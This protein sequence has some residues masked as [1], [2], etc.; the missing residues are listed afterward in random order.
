MSD[1]RVYDA[2]IIGS[3]PNGLAAGIALSQQGYCVLILEAADTVGGGT[4]TEE[5]TLPGFL[6]DR[7]S[8]VHPMGVLSP[9]FQQLPLEE[10]G[11]EWIHPPFS[12]A[13]PMEQGPAVL[14]EESIEETALGLGGLGPDAEAYRKLVTPFVRHGDALMGDLLAPLRF[15]RFPLTMLRFGWLGIKSARSLAMGRFSG[16]AA[17]ALFAGCAAHSILPLERRLS[18]AV[19]LVFAVSGHLKSWPVAR[20][21]SQKIAE[22][23]ASYFTSLG[24]EI[25]TGWPVSSLEEVPETRAVIFDTSPAVMA[26]IA[27]EELPYGYQRRLK[28]Y[29]YG[30][31]AFKVDWALSEAIPWKDPRC[32][33]ASTVHVGGTFDEVAAAEAAAWRGDTTERPFVLMTQQSH[34]DDSRAPEGKHT[35]YGYCHVPSGST[36]DMTEAIEKQIERFAPGFRDCIEGRFVTTPTDFAT[37]N[38]NNHGGAITG[39]VADLFQLFTRPV[40]RWNPYTTP[41]RRIFICS[42]STP[43]GGGVH[44]M[45]GYWAAQIVARRLRKL[46][47]EP[48][49]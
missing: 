45:C 13:H 10:H 15:P 48:T 36:V 31:A 5:L 4:R 43:P 6:H 37:Y 23:L 16:E 38:P 32:A 39:G 49:D 42:A 24:G 34:F 40:A 1:K 27:G 46:S 17:R 19:G 22:A 21:G 7:C 11:L 20:G 30:P 9:F 8:A 44:G 47:I 2:V 28:R 18:A 14:L 35:G 29:R 33:Q 26:S 12:V 3:G 41:N 25:R